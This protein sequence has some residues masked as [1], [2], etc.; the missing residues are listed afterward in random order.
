MSG[1]QVSDFYHPENYPNWA[2]KF[3]VQMQYS[4]F[5]RAILSTIRNY[6]GVRPPAYIHLG[7]LNK[8]VRL[9]WGKEDQTVPFEG[10]KRIRAVVETEFWALMKR[11]IYHIMKSPFWLILGCSVF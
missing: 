1:A 7:E 10:N 5:K 4:G 2:E 8:L 6:H 11:D 3:E 9:I